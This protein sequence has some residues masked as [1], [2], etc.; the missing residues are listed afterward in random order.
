MRVSKYYKKLD[1]K[2]LFIAF[3]LVLAIILSGAVS[4]AADIQ[5]NQSVNNTNPNYNETVKLTT[6]VTNNGPDT[7][8]GV[9]IT[10]KLP[11]NLTYISDDSNGAY[12]PTTGIW[13]IGTINYGDSPKSLNIIT[14]VNGTGT[15]KNLAS[16]T[17]QTNADPKLDNDAQEVVL[18]VPEAADIAIDNYL[19]YPDSNYYYSNTPVFVVDVRNRGASGLSDATNIVVTYT[20]GSGYEFIAFNT[21]GVGTATYDENTRTITWNIPLIPKGVNS[22][23]PAWMNV[24]LRVIT[25]GNQTP[26]LTN[27]AKLVSLDQYDYNNANNEKGIAITVPKAHDIEVK[28][29]FTTSTNMNG[30]KLVTYYITATNNGPDDAQGVIIKDL[31]PSGLQWLSDD[32]GIYYNHTTGIWNVGNIANGTTKTLIITANITATNG[33]IKNSA[34]LTAPLTPVFT[35]WNYNNNG[36]T[37]DLI[38]SGT[39]TPKT[40]IVVDNYL[41]YPD[42]SY[43]Y[44]NTPV[45]VVDVRNRGSTAEY[46]DATN[47]VVTYTIGS[48]YEFI[49]FNTR[50]VGTATYDENTRTI[51]WNIPLMAKGLNSGGPA[52]MNVYVRVITT[53]NQTSAL[54]NTATLVSPVYSTQ[55]SKSLAITVPAAHDVEVKQTI[56]GTTKYQDTV[57]I[58]INATNNGPGDATGVKIKDIL[59]S[60]LQWISDDGGIYYNHT[61]GIWNVGNI[62]NG[63][64]KTLTIIA[65]IISTGTISNS[66]I[67]TAPLTPAFTDWNYN[68]NGQTVEIEVP[69]AADIGVSQS[70]NNTT[71]TVNDTVSITVNASNNGPNLATGIKISDI[72][73]SGLEFVSCST[74]Y[75]SYSNGIWTIENLLSGQIATL[76]I[77][78]KA[79][80]V[81]NFT[82]IINKTFANQFDWNNTNNMASINLAI[83][84]KIPDDI[85]TNEGQQGGVVNSD[86][87]TTSAITLPFP[88]TFYGQTYNTIYINV[89][90]LISF[91]TPMPGPY[92]RDYPDNVPY[93]AAFWGDLDITHA[94]SIYYTIENDKIIITWDKVPGY[95]QTDKFNTFR[96]IIRSNGTFTFDY[97]DMEMAND[98]SNIN[99]KVLINSG[100]G[101]NPTKTFWNGAQD[102]NL[103]DNKEI[104][105]DS[106]GNLLAP[107]SHIGITYTVN[108]NNPN[109][110]DNVVY[111]INATNNGASTATNVNIKSL[112]PSGLTYVSSS[113]PDYNS[114]TGI[115]DISTLA[116]GTSA[117]LTITAKVTGAGTITTY[118]N[119]TAQDQ[120]DP[121]AYD[122]K[123]LTLTVPQ[124]HVAVTY[125]VNNSAPNYQG[126]VVYT[127]TAKNNGPNTATGINITS[128]LPSGLTF[129]SS[130][131]TNYDSN[132]GIWNVGTLTNGSSVTLTIT[133]KVAQ[134]GTITTYANT[135]AQNQYDPTG[136]D[137]KTL[138][139]TVPKAADIGVTVSASNT[140]P[141]WLSSFDIYV[142]VVNNGPDPANGVV[143]TTSLPSGINYNSYSSSQGSYNSN[144]GKWTIGTLNPGQTVRLTLHV[145]RSFI[146][147]SKTVTAKKTAETE[148]DPVTTNNS[149]S[150][151]IRS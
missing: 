10:T 116:P 125:T 16:K 48:G 77:I 46:D 128:K 54:T 35:D 51:T 146:S 127:I 40:N 89:N 122:G 14:R 95:T 138:T 44:S 15:I 11:D 84:G 56:T 22:G 27:T 88:V 66:A 118:A 61:T 32:G 21:R 85:F 49:A 141:G 31:L 73:P 130:S 28:Q 30:D 114:D 103:I 9:Q 107:N 137:K 83:S 148:Y 143:I 67:L 139:L 18:S 69:A 23:G 124:S 117:I 57:T 133:A 8:T 98:L 142:D 93:I 36:Q 150:V 119:T 109:Y 1:K 99:S 26:E 72:L 147:G 136:Y 37:T 19:W 113:S 58:T 75:G 110:Q 2:L 94:G 63:T 149:G 38:V 90:G 13:N 25:T 62:A 53:G 102:L 108:N 59:P 132:T 70:I 24:Y 45:F 87:G 79:V 111:T 115:W 76:T 80:N 34:I 68:N 60:G 47:V 65:K 39:Y 120:Y 100:S 123:T 121:N 91:G 104:N 29:T 112:L 12:N 126:T 3:S 33:T 86:D 135:T 52:W 50:G 145:T 20:I 101:T 97:D 151:V 5:V 74:N 64:S 4:A 17:V 71:P 96:I 42:S 7:A 105:F 129:V 81:G 82:N 144:T 140:T 131:S 43:Y 55:P 106:N 92:Y 6:T 41:W 78:A 134:T